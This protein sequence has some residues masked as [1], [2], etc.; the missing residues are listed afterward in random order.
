MIDNRVALPGVEVGDDVGVDR[1]RPHRRL[2]RSRRR[3]ADLADVGEA[4][5]PPC[6]AEDRVELLQA[7]VEAL[8][9]DDPLVER[10]RR[11][12]Q[13]GADRLYRV[14]RDALPVDMVDILVRREREQNAEHDRPHLAGE[15]APAVQRFDRFEHPFD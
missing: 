1:G 7:A 11:V 10:P 3:A 12:S 15:R 14:A 8:L 9:D 13:L 5:G 2:D 6:L 4:P